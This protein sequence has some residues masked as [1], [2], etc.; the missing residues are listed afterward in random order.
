M[1]GPAAT[2]PP[3]VV[4]VD[5]SDSAR[6]AAE[7]AADLAAV[8][9]CPLHLVHVVPG[10]PQDA[11]PLPV[12]LWLREVVDAA[13]RT[14]ADAADIEIVSGGTDRL[15]LQRAA[16]AE[17]LVVGS[18]GEA[19]WS[20]ML[21]GRTG[22]TLV[23]RAPCPVAVVRGRAPRIP[24]PR[25]GPVV[26]GVDGSP[27]SVR[28]LVLGADLAAA[29]GADLLAVHAFTDV[30]ASGGSPHRRQEDWA[31]LVAEAEAELE[32]TAAAAIA[33][34]PQVRF[35]YRVV[36][37][38]T[39]RVLIDQAESARAVV[40]GQRDER[41]PAGE[42]VLGSTSRGLV[43]FAP[44]PVVVLPATASGAGAAPAQAAAP[45]SG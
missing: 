1:T 29:T 43:E 39:L 6:F 13:V 15:L 11:A 20:G 17:L 19:A 41:S 44:C 28:A 27:A 37:G 38:T 4:G 32:Q 21:A 10:Y 42:M 7:W 24:P 31:R 34:R 5:S 36:A 25:Q 30:S 16:G 22:L 2:R 9:G 18:Y 12:P 14:G 3:I 8:R 35:S 33:D 23:E 26:V 45:T 40:V